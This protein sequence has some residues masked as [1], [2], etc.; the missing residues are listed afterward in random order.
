MDDCLTLLSPTL[1]V[2][3]HRPLLE[4]LAAEAET[5]LPDETAG[6]LLGRV[7]P[8]GTDVSILVAHSLGGG[9]SSPWAMRL[10]AAV[11]IKAHWHIQQAHPELELVGW[12]HTHPGHGIFLSPQDW[13]LHERKFA[14]AAMPHASAWVLDPIQRTF[15]AFYGQV[16]QPLPQP[17][18]LSGD[19]TSL[20]YAFH[21]DSPFIPAGGFDDI[22]G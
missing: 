7:A 2:R 11:W 14:P 21:L 4:A 16:E 3:L 13:D 19:G 15:G 9:P 18:S 1:T 20:P 12:Y 10:P 8:D 22:H 17:F 5:A 6:L